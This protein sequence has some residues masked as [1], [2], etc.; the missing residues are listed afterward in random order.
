MKLF[1]DSRDLSKKGKHW[2]KKH[3]FSRMD[4]CSTM[5]GN[6]KD[7]KRH[8]EDSTS[9]FTYIHCRNHCLALC[10]AQMVP[11][12]EAFE[13]FDSPW[14]NLFL[15]MKN[16]CVKQAIF[17]EVQSSYVLTSLKLIKAVVMWWLRRMTRKKAGAKFSETPGDSRFLFGK[18]VCGAFR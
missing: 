10:F 1:S 16:S 14:L 9:Y 6:H 15:L 17:E 7:I 8:S 2:H 4:R 11:Q 3:A 18:L 12:Y 5:G 13:K